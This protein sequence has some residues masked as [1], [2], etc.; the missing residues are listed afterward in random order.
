M[1]NKKILRRLNTEVPKGDE[2]AD[3][4]HLYPSVGKGKQKAFCG[5]MWRYS[6][7][8]EWYFTSGEVGNHE[9]CQECLETEEFALAALG[10]V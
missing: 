5:A 8:L 9:M 10:C 2:G 3:Y 6:A 4:L 7:P 1:N